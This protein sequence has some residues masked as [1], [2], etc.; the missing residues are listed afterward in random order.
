MSH[1]AVLRQP[2]ALGERTEKDLHKEAEMAARTL[3][4]VTNLKVA[5]ALA[6]TI[7]QS[8]LQRAEVVE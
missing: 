5:K 1:V 7:P 8:L 3:E 4:L 6:L 2:G